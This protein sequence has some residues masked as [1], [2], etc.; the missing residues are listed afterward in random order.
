MW[1]EVYQNSLVLVREFPVSP[2]TCNPEETGLL[3][4][5][6]SWSPA[7]FSGSGSIG[8]PPFPWTKINRKFAIFR[9]KWSSLLPRR[10]G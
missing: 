8:L 9:P 6:L 7:L 10:S 2:G 3:G 4:L 5:P 1:R